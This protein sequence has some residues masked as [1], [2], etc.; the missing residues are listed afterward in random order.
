MNN[1]RVCKTKCESKAAKHEAM[2]ARAAVLRLCRRYVNRSGKP[3]VLR[4]GGAVMIKWSDLT[5][6]GKTAVLTVA[7]ILE[8]WLLWG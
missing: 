7:L 5:E 8:A 6:D 4:G 1:E 3:V 2:G